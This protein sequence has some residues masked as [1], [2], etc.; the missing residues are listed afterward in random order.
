M[1]HFKHHKVTCL[2]RISTDSKY[3][4]TW[5]RVDPAPGPRALRDFLKLDTAKHTGIQ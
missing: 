1:K 3:Y 2:P 4:T 5:G